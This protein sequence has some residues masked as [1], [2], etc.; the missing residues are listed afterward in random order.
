MPLIIMRSSTSS[1]EMAP[2]KN[3]H[4]KLGVFLLF[5]LI[6]GNRLIR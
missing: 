5:F 2:T 4:S 1:A 6:W 3:S